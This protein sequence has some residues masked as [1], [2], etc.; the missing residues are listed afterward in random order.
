VRPAAGQ[1]APRASSFIELL[2]TPDSVTA[3]G[4]F[5]KTLPSSR[6]ALQPAGVQWRAGEVTVECAVAQD[7]LALMLAAPSTPDR[8][9]ACALALAG[10]ARA[11]RVGMRGSVATE[12]SAGVT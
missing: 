3:Y 7:A 2:R 10:A 9:S 1:R 11:A 12:S 4:S 6:I 5:V 8:R